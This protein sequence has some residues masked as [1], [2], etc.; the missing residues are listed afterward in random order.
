MQNTDILYRRAKLGGD[1]WT[2]D[3]WK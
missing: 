2:H 3:D 1:W